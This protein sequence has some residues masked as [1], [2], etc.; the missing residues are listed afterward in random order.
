MKQ[1]REVQQIEVAAI[2]VTYHPDADFPTRLSR[3]RGQVK[4]VVIVDNG[5]GPEQQDMLS[6][7]ETISNVSVLKNDD[8]IGI[9]TALNQGFYFLKEVGYSWAITLDQDSTPAPDMVENLLKALKDC[10][11]PEKIALIG[12]N[13]IDKGMSGAPHK[14]FRPKTS[15]PFFERVPCEN[16]GPDGIS[17][18][19][20]SGALTNLKI[21]EKI[22]QFD[23]SLFI[24]FV[25]TE[26]CL[27]AKKAGYQILVSCSAKLYHQLGSKRRVSIFGLKL[28]PTFHE[29][30]RRYYLCRNRIVMIRRY[31]LVFPHWLIYEF[32]A[33]LHSTLCILLCEDEKWAKLMAG[34]VGTWDG[35][36]GHLGKK[37][38][39]NFGQFNR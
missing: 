38:K 25:D 13:R 37:N 16:I 17:I 9:A 18:V 20:T 22:G 14:W 10:A 36:R 23:D 15:F 1:P 33:A 24:D 32:A 5:S 35:L 19:I 21:L 11:E 7:I 8:N 29:P 31:G 2:I 4:H 39:P 30:I 28:T 6:S 3:I 27:R 34:I 12:P 26:Y